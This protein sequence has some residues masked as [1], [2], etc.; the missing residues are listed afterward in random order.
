MFIM[1]INLL[2]RLKDHNGGEGWGSITYDQG[3]YHSSNVAI[4]NLLDQ[5]YV[6]KDVLTEKLNDLGFFQGDTVM[7]LHVHHQSMLIQEKNAG[8]LEYLTTGF[9]QGST[10]TPYQTF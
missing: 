8:R 1:E 6:T 2:Q 10:V 4:C 7:D 9:G 3:L 5:G